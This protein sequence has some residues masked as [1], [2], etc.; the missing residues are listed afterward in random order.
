[1]KSV[2]K[3]HP[4]LKAIRGILVE[5]PT[6]MCIRRIWNFGSILGICLIV[7]ILS[8]LFLVFHYRA[9]VRLAFWVVSSGMNDVPIN[10]AIR[11]T[12]ANGASAFFLFLYL[13]VARGLYYGSFYFVEV[14]GVG[15]VILL[16]VIAAAFLG[17][18]LPWG[19][20]S[21]WGATVITRLF[22]AIPYLGG[23]IVT[24]LWGG[25]SVDNSTLVR[26]LG[27]HFIIPL[28]VAS[29]V[30]LHLVFLHIRGSRSPLGVRAD[31]NKVKFNQYFILKDAIG[32]FLF[33]IGL[34]YF[35]FF[36]PWDL[37]DPENFIQA[38][39]LVT[40]AHIQPEWYFLFAYAILR[41]IPRKLGGVVA[42][43]ASVL[44]LGL[45]PFLPR[46]LIKGFRFYPIRKVFFWRFVVVVLLLTWI[47]ARPVEEPYVATGQVLRVL[48]FLYYPLFPALQWAQDYAR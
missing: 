21:F 15:V 32:A 42:L 48:Y 8:G 39:P 11:I 20:M 6:P 24:W 13:H 1:M 45:V 4:L 30:G 33:F 18:V 43:A 2:I 47:G 35:V 9:D 41:A 36:Q 29:L 23:D 28:V 37:G 12:H 31:Y 16:L 5:L 10:W 38:N 46:A 22:S 25:F 26:F 27:F 7:Q 14:W 44:V 3:N 19:Q 40:P 34:L 17:Y